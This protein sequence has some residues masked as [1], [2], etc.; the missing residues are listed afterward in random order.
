MPLGNDF[1]R[2]SAL[3]KPIDDLINDISALVSPGVEFVRPSQPIS[4]SEA[5]HVSVFV[6]FLPILCKLGG[7][8]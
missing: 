8:N 6:L 3:V 1:S 2:D 4:V 7:S 5:T